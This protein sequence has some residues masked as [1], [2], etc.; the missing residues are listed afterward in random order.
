VRIQFA[1]EGGVGYFPALSKPV[2]I[3]IDRLDAGEAEDLK[4]LVKAA[5]FFDLPVAIG[6]PAPGSA[7]YQ[8]YTLTIEDGKRRHT[9]RILVPVENKAIQDLVSAVQ[10]QVKAARTASRRPPADPTSGKPPS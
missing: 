1:Q 2:T 6:T 4:R 8:H 7:D 5:H 9:V 3:E 10:M